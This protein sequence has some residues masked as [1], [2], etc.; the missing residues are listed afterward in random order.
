MKIN[1]ISE[2][3]DNTISAPFSPLES[4][5]D[6]LRHFEINPGYI[7]ALYSVTFSHRK[8][9]QKYDGPDGCTS[10]GSFVLTI[11]SGQKFF[12]I[13]MGDIKLPA[14]I[15]DGDEVL[16]SPLLDKENFLLR[17][18]MDKLIQLI[19]DLPNE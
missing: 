6:L 4:A 12:F 10:Y 16:R 2:I 9:F 15:I 5:K 3:V 1:K 11:N 7:T 19:K 17:P 8:T 18:D 14:F 13:D